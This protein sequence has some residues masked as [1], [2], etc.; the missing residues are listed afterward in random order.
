MIEF[1]L[2]ILAIIIVAMR[3]VLGAMCDEEKTRRSK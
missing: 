2:F 3:R 1:G